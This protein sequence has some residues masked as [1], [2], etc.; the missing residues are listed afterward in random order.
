MPILSGVPYIRSTY[1]IWGF[2]I[3]ATYAILGVLGYQG[4]RFWGLGF[5]VSD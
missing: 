2:L 1:A 3:G 4:F 5:S